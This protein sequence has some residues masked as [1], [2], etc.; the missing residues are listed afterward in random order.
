MSKELDP[1]NFKK[2]SAADKL[3]AFHRAE[4][5][6]DQPS[7][8]GD[9][10]RELQ[11]QAA[12]DAGD[13]DFIRQATDGLGVNTGNAINSPEVFAGQSAV[14]LDA[15]DEQQLR[16]LAVSRGLDHRGKL[17]L[18]KDRL[19]KH[20]VQQEAGRQTRSIQTGAQTAPA[21]P[22]DYELLDEPELKE[23]ARARRLD[24]RGDKAELV[25]RL[26]LDD[27]VNQPSKAQS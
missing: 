24:D 13:D 4:W 8:S 18:V 15:M 27:Q 20:E 26:K 2:W 25:E 6:A 1:K 12:A 19:R 21:E 14:D 9:E 16:L 3:Y 5:P 17:D 7:P 23:L 11:A 10:L 22:V